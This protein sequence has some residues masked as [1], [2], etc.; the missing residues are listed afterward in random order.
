MLYF[1]FSWISSTGFLYQ[2]IINMRG[3]FG[4]SIL[5]CT[6]DTDTILQDYCI[7]IEE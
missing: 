3:V 5:N 6:K 7:S 2:K 1:R 4:P